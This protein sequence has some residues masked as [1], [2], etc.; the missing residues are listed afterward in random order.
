M[1][2]SYGGSG[3]VVA[4]GADSAGLEGLLDRGDFLVRG[5]LFADEGNSRVW[6]AGEKLGRHCAAL[7]AID[8]TRVDVIFASYVFG[9]TFG[10]GSHAPL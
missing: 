1:E 4:D 8:A 9:K 6:V 10:E 3:P 2:I 5:R 7:V